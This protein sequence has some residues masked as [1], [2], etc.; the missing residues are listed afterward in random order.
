MLDDCWVEINAFPQMWMDTLCNS[1]WE[2]REKKTTH[3]NQRRTPN[4]SDHR[5]NTAYKRQLVVSNGTRAVKTK[6]LKI[7]SLKREKPNKESD[8][9]ESWCVCVCMCGGGG[10]GVWG[11]GGCYCLLER[12]W[13]EDSQPINLSVW[14]MGHNYI[15]CKCKS[16]EFIKLQTII[17]NN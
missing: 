17:C 15:I 14:E 9:T 6:P 2:Q 16:E 10:G 12:A 4:E 11:W 1:Q 7:F 3:M 13:A 5:P 8:R